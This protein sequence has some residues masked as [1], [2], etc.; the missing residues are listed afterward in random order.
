M[1][2]ATDTPGPRPTLGVIEGF[3]GRAWSHE[4]RLFLLKVISHL[5]LDAYLYAPKNDATL[6]KAW[7]VLRPPAARQRLEE[8]AAAAAEARVAFAVGLS[9]FALYLNYDE[10]ARRTLRDRLQELEDCGVKNL[11]LLFDDMPGDV[12]D[13]AERQIDIATDIRAWIPDLALRVCPTYYSDDPV[14][15]RVFGARPAS[16][17]ETL[18]QGLPADVPIFWT[19][20]AVCAT[21][22][23]RSHLDRVRAQA[24]RPLALWDNYP[25]NDSRARSEHLYVSPLANRAAAVGAGLE[26]HWCNAMNQMALSLPALASLGQLYDRSPTGRAEVLDE[27]GV[28]AELIDA[29]RPLAELER[30]ALPAA[31]RKDLRRLAGAPTRAARELGAWLD[32]AY[33]FDPACLTD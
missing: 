27:A 8:L 12:D 6:R 28:G 24:G 13:L 29:C 25:V 22:F 17:L 21:G 9:P 31:L 32:G 16:Y 15:D 26:S 11:A 14:L 5:G 2:R 18:G 30:C 23:T 19:G 10:R 1:N 20:D 4:D 33:E 7:R 3:Y